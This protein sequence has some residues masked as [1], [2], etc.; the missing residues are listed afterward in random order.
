MPLAAQQTRPARSLFGRPCAALF[1]SVLLA[2]FVGC[3]NRQQEL[4]ESDLRKKEAEIDELRAKAGAKDA[5]IQSLE[6]ELEMLQR[7]RAKDAKQNP[8]GSPVGAVF[9]VEKITLG[10]LSGGVRE[11]SQIEGDDAL[12]ILLEPR[13]ADDSVVK[14]PGSVKIEVFEVNAQGLKSFLSA[15]ELS[16]RELRPK[17]DSPLI[18]SSGY[19]ITLPWKVYPTTEK[20]KVIVRFTTLDGQQFETEKD[21]TVKLLEPR[22][23][24]RNCV[25]PMPPGTASGPPANL[26][27]EVSQPELL[28]P[29]T[30]QAPALMIAEPT[31]TST[32]TD[33]P[34]PHQPSSPRPM[35]PPY[36]APQPSSP[37]P[38]AQP[39]KSTPSGDELLP[40]PKPL[41]LPP[42]NPPLSFEMKPFTPGREPVIQTGYRQESDSAKGDRLPRL[43]PPQGA[44]LD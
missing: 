5:E 12:Q 40:A 8:G 3:A 32:R 33:R 37:R 24:A 34:V 26:P 29:P 17:W 2:G 11:N 43:L 39:A 10:R 9:L 25:T 27:G 35:L 14:A 7:C 42:L 15:W 22:R 36:P 21:V 16:P 30:R 44:K 1:L 19:R 4:I 20:L 23:R 38:G 6:I 41:T 28:G 13:D 18:G 31:P